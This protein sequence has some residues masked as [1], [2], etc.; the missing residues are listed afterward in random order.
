M[1]QT[2]DRIIR[3]L[4]E[5]IKQGNNLN[6]L[7]L[8]KIAQEAEIGKSTVYEHFKSKEDMI[9]S[10]YAYLLNQ[11]KTILLEPIEMKDFKASFKAQILR[12]LFVMRDAKNIMDAIMDIQLDGIPSLKQEHQAL[13]ENIQTEMNAR[14]IE[15]MKLGVHSKE[16]NPSSMN[17]YAKYII[18][19]L[20][21][22]LL[23]SYLKEDMGLT[24][25]GI[26]DLIYN[27]VLKALN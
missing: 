24:E 9:S 18:Q 16:F 17:P 15:I 5:H 13:M 4:V 10:T 7:S 23:L 8:S 26:T 20:I 21:S 27:Q 3:V 14:F 19:S 6:E 11:Y 12:I 25:D 22:G 1:S 2:K